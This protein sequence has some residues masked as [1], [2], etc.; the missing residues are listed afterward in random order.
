MKKKLFFITVYLFLYTLVVNGQGVSKLFGLV[1]GYP[2]SDQ[3]S[4]GYLFSTDSSG[5][6]FQIQYNFPVTTFGANP[7]NVELAQYGSKLYGTTRFGGVNNSGTIFEYDPV[8]NIYTKKFDFAFNTTGGEPRGSLL[9][10]NSKFYGI[11][12]AYGNG[13][14]GTIFEWDP[15]TNI[16]TKKYDLTAAGGSNPQNSLKLYNNKMYGT[17]LQGGSANVGVLFQWDPATNVYTDLFDLTGYPGNGYGFLNNVT[18][19]N[20]KL[21]CMSQQGA[22]NNYGALYVVDPSLPNGSNATVIK[23]FDG[24]TG[25]NPNNNDMIVYNNKLYGCLYSAGANSSGTLFQ[26]DPATNTF[27]KLVDFNYTANGAGPLGKLVLNGTKFLGMCNIGGVNGTGT[28]YEWDPANPTTVVKK[29]DFDVNNN[30]NPRNPGIAM[31]LYNSKFY[32]TTYNGGFTDQGTLFTYDYTANTLTKKLNFNA[33][34]NGRI[35]YSRPVLLSGKIYGTCYTGPQ[36]D[37]GCIWEYDPST[38]IYSRKFLFS[39]ANNTANGR[40]PVAPPIV[41]NNKLYGL[42]TAGGVSDYGVVYEFDPA[43]NIYNKKD[44]QTLGTGFS[45]D[46]ELT[47]FN[48]KMY[49]MLGNGGIGNLGIIFSY[50]PAT[51]LLT[52][53][54]DIANLGNSNASPSSYFVVYN[55]KLYGC[56][57]SGGANNSGAIFSFDPATNLAVSLADI[58]NPVTG[59]NIRNAFTVYN[60]KLYNTALSGGSNGRGTIL[61]FDPATNTIATVFNCNTTPGGIGYD[62]R[63]QLTINGNKM[64]TVTWDNSAITNVVELDPATSTV[65]KKSTYT[66]PSPFN[67]T[68]SHNSVTVVPAFIANGIP[69]S[70]ET[71]PTVVINGSNN[72]QWVPILNAAGDVVAELKANGN[73]LGT[74]TTSAYINNGT[75]R[76]DASKQLYMDRNITIAVQNQPSSNVDIRLYIKASEYL[77]MKNATNSIGQPSGI[78]SISDIAILKNPQSCTSSLSINPTILTTTFENYEYGY[79][80]K[81]SISSFST[82]FFAKSTFTVLPVTVIS[83]NAVKQNNITR[84]SWQTEN[85]IGFSNFEVQRNTG[86]NVWQTVAIVNARNTSGIN[87]Y[88]TIDANPANGT[89]FYRLKENDINGSFKY[90]QIAKVDFTKALTITISPNPATQQIT[91]Q[92]DKKISSIILLDMSGKLVKQLPLSQNNSYDVS[93]IAPGI[94]LLKITAGETLETVKLVKQ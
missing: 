21:Y 44:I 41:Y 52:K 2:Q 13:A 81:A 72:N 60:N 5:N 1:G 26:V 37:A 30:D 22:A 65:T 58:N 79:V 32:G 29:Y 3:S 89:N 36:P 68:V 61:S 76:E 55:N 11:A 73:N 56:T 66:S 4:N 94:Y 70:C 91:I 59:S 10:Y 23:D 83:F 57:N 19:Y 92:S 6:N 87:T 67:S 82:F 80:L 33:A 25:G 39:Y 31:F 86:N 28:I 27:T 84:L 74:V 54:Y 35:P 64:Y 53:L 7:Q 20:S 71:Y 12:G 8:T 42:T 40:A 85:E 17:T 15:A 9:L 47:V 43:T 69:N 63:G 50:D 51:T 93:D 14:A 34:E 88:S 18:V 62:P 48:N 24:T 46:G 38:A 75:V 45:P 77:T 16:F 90:S 78:T 49:G